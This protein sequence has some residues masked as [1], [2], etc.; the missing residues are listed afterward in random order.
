MF[1]WLLAI[2]L[3]NILIFL[4]YSTF[5]IHVCFVSIILF[6]IFHTLYF[7]HILCFPPDIPHLP[8]SILI[9]H[10]VSLSQKENNKRKMNN[11]HKKSKSK[12]NKKSKRKINKKR[13]AKAEQKAHMHTNAV[14]CAGE[15]VLVTFNTPIDIL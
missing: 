10:S 5:G 13:N 9:P 8:Y 11:N 12:Q 7:N 1:S 4:V 15:L 2:L 6:C 3:V 14:I